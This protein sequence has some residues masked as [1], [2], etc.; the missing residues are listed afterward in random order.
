MSLV[1]YGNEFSTVQEWVHRNEYWNMEHRSGMGIVWYEV[2]KMS[3]IMVW[4]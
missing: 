2:W 4:E 1:Q 3:G